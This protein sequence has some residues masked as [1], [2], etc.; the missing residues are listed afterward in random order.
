MLECYY[1][2]GGDWR[3]RG[4]VTFTLPGIHLNG[5]AHINFGCPKIES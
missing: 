2:A 5:D 3:V 1:M 4:S